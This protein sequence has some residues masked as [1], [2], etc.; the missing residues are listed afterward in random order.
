MHKISIS[1]GRNFQ[2]ENNNFVE[3]KFFGENK[4]EKF[5][6]MLP[7]DNCYYC[8]SDAGISRLAIKKIVLSLF[9][10]HGLMSKATLPEKINE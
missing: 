3:K 7:E 2:W 8:F 10:S 1:Q 9:L 4:C 5:M 6:S